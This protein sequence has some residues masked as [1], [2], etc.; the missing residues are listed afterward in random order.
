MAKVLIIDLVRPFYTESASLGPSPIRAKAP[1]DRTI[2][3]GVSPTIAKMRDRVT[4]TGNTIVE[5]RTIKLDGYQQVPLKDVHSITEFIT[6]NIDRIDAV[7]VWSSKNLTSIFGRL[8][9]P[10][11][12]AFLSSFDVS[13]IKLMTYVDELD[14]SRN[15]FELSA[16]MN[17]INPALYAPPMTDDEVTGRYKSLCTARYTASEAR[18]KYAEDHGIVRYKWPVYGTHRVVK[19]Y[20]DGD[21]SIKLSTYEMTSEEDIGVGVLC[22]YL[23]VLLRCGDATNKT[24]MDMIHILPSLAKT[25]L[26]IRREGRIVSNKEIFMCHPYP[27]VADILNMCRIDYLPPR[28]PYH[29][30][31]TELGVRRAG[32][33]VLPIDV[34]SEIYQ[35]HAKYA[36]AAQKI[37]DD[38]KKGHTNTRRRDYH[39]RGVPTF[40][41]D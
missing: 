35:V 22:Q 39:G 9:T 5:E 34:P 4:G 17:A 2:L 1:K 41:L 7:M 25:K 26:V 32:A 38:V 6:T 15:A 29:N 31:W 23:S 11:L 24:V 28:R 13:P 36:E 14:S 19:T 12:H 37:L 21:H 3:T 8:F 40:S 10:T 18:R 33:S 30:A 20:Q 27:I 16:T